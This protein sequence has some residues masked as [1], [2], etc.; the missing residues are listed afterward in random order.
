MKLNIILLTYN[1]KHPSE[2]GLRLGYQAG[3][4]VFLFG[5]PPEGLLLPTPQP[6]VEEKKPPTF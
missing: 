2:G 1:G 6:A 3:N 4:R 5:G